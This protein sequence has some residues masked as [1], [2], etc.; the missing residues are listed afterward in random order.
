[1]DGGVIET[2]H[3]SVLGSKSE[4]AEQ[5]LYTVTTLLE[6]TSALQLWVITGI[7]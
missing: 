1:M 5:L 4:S 3:V 2:S 7:F 6:D